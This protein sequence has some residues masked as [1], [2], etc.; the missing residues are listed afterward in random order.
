[1][2]IEHIDC[3]PQTHPGAVEERSFEFTA[4]FQSAAERTDHPYFRQATT[5]DVGR[6][7]ASLDKTETCPSHEMVLVEGLR[8]TRELSLKVTARAD[9]HFASLETD[10]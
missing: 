7:L 2:A 4:D 6:Q 9:V 10:V 1:M 8:R 3:S 5:T